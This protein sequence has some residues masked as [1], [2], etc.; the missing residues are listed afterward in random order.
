MNIASGLPQV[1]A[2]TSYL[3]TVPVIFIY[4]I[5]LGVFLLLAKS[6]RLGGLAFRHVILALVFGVFGAFL[7]LPPNWQASANKL[8][9]TPRRLS[10]D[11]ILGVLI[12]FE[13]IMIVRDRRKASSGPE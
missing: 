5:A 6:E 4:A 13:I 2:F 8:T 3:H 9:S 10:T 12:L 11:A 1:S 7:L